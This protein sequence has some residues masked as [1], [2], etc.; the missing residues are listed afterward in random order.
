M[1]IL[2]RVFVSAVL[3][4]GRKLMANGCLQE[5]CTPKIM[6]ISNNV[7]V[8]LYL[9]SHNHNYY[10]QQISICQQ[11]WLKKVKLRPDPIF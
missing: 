6:C 9:L 2:K 7:L 10:K 4:F 5:L 8:I 11:Q 3:L 1:L